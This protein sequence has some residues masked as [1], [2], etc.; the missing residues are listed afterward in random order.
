MVKNRENMQCD[1][2]G[3]P[4]SADKKS[5][6]RNYLLLSLLAGIMMGLIFPLFASLFTHY[7][8]PAYQLP[9]TLCCV[10][11]GCIVG[12]ISFLIGK[13]TL[14]HSIRRFFR[15]FELIAEG[16]L[17]V[18]CQMRSADELGQLADEFNEFIEKM[19]EIFRHNQASA[20]TTDSLA[21]TLGESAKASERISGEIV[22][23]TSTIA[24]GA[25][26]QSDQIHLIRTEMQDGTIYM[27]KG[28]T[29]A[30]D[31][32]SVSDKAVGLAR[33]GYADMSS[34]AEQF[35]WIRT[36]IAYAA[37]AIQTLGSRSGEIGKIL[38]L[39]QKISAQTNLLS[40]NAS[41]EAA[42]AGEAGKGF[43]I[44]A[45]EIRELSDQTVSASAAINQIIGA[46]QTETSDSMD[47]MKKNLEQVNVQLGSIQ[48]SISVLKTI[49]E[50]VDS[51]HQNASEVLDIYEMIRSKFL[52]LDKSVIQIS[53]VVESN[54]NYAQEVAAATMDQH[55]S[56]HAVRTSAAKM[57]EVADN[58]LRDISRYKTE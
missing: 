43:A 26:H 6:I 23:G 39:I 57:T 13:F 55:N 17:T 1:Q 21:R 51:T 4:S 2:Q 35:E 30:R 32:M 31:L 10:V 42:R 19:Q 50:T 20:S 15:T 33:T 8:S 27:E 44:V 22:K 14:I 48:D 29:C 52:A 54:A 3:R 24:E 49:E 56:V 25:Q 36:T 18:R 45:E 5:I 38:Q 47:H 9:F 58:M 40:L 11:A 41:I 28:V 7:K 37:E 12:V 46:I 53:D 16:D 34:V